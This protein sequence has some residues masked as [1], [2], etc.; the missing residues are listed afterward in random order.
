MRLALDT[1]TTWSSIALI[2]D[3]VA[4]A[5]ADIDGVNPGEIVVSRIDQLLKSADVDRSALTGIVVGVG[6]GPY[7]STRVGVAIA[8]TLGFAL[9]IDVV[10]VCSHDAIAAEFVASGSHANGRDFVVATDARRREVYWA[11]YGASGS[12][13][14]GPAVAKPTQ[15]LDGHADLTWVGNGLERYPE[16]VAAAGLTVL[17]PAHPSAQWLVHV[18]AS[19]WAAGQRVPAVGPELADHDSGAAAPFDENQRL[20]APIPLYLRRPDAVPA[21]HVVVPS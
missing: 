3:G 14:E 2:D 8:R 5:L 1:S 15:L 4:V 16:L 9:G 21:A 7:T 13:C 19:A 18:A 20:F 6:P 12:R 17:P 10:G 11:R